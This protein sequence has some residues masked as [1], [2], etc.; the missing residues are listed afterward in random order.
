M[1]QAAVVIKKEKA[2]AQRA[3]ARPHYDQ[4]LDD[5]PLMALLS[6]GSCV[7]FDT[8]KER[9]TKGS[10]GKQAAQQVANE[11]QHASVTAEPAADERLHSEV[12]TLQRKVSD[13]EQAVS[14]QR[15][16]MQVLLDQ[17]DSEAKN[18]QV[19]AF[20]APF[21][22]PRLDA[23]L[24]CRCTRADDTRACVVSR[25]AQVELQRKSEDLQTLQR[26]L[27]TLKTR[28]HETLAAGQAL[29][30]FVP[31]WHA[32]QLTPSHAFKTERQSK[33]KAEENLSTRMDE[34]QTLSTALQESKRNQEALEREIRA[35]CAT[36]KKLEQELQ[37]VR[38]HIAHDMNLQSP[39]LNRPARKEDAV[40]LISSSPAA[41]NFETYVS[42]LR[43]MDVD[44]DTGGDVEVSS[45]TRGGWGIQI[46]SGP[47]S[48]PD[49][50]YTREGRGTNTSEDHRTPATGMPRVSTQQY[51]QQGANVRT[52]VQQHQSW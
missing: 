42:N 23:C 3:A 50:L 18:F 2:R 19:A 6:D 52:I 21:C 35:R 4:L 44:Q 10:E 17:K 45:A 20:T 39:T 16:E 51:R 12:D 36:E 40:R 5:C 13:L 41:N 37:S 11:N 33:L 49:H 27:A 29:S 34:L 8:Q 32:L 38:K 1:E 7:F 47:A 28:S 25:G 48:A 30:V 22:L 26:D 24:L 46:A 15:H 43:S 9:Q 31:V 14:S